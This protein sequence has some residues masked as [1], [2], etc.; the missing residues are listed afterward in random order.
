MGVGG[1]DPEEVCMEYLV[2][3]WSV[4]WEGMQ[5][6][7]ES[8]RHATDTARDL[9]GAVVRYWGSTDLPFAG[10]SRAWNSPA[11]HVRHAQRLNARGA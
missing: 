6:Q 2:C 7:C 3:E 9:P 5:Q 11:A 4:E 10:V 8:R 1:G